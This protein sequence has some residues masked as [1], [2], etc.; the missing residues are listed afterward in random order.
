MCTD[1]SGIIDVYALSNQTLIDRLFYQTI[2]LVADMNFVRD[3]GV[4]GGSKGLYTA[5][6]LKK[7]VSENCDVFTAII[8]ETGIIYSEQQSGIRAPGDDIVGDHDIF[9]AVVQI[10]TAVV[11]IDVITGDKDILAAPDTDAVIPSVADNIV[12]DGGAFRIILHALRIENSL[13]LQ[14]DAVVTAFNTDAVPDDVV[15]IRPLSSADA[16]AGTSGTVVVPFPTAPVD[17]HGVNHHIVQHINTQGRSGG[18]QQPKIPEQRWP[19]LPRR[20]RLK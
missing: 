3:L 16:D 4:G 8:T 17:I 1:F 7:A 13:V 12:S 18:I 10:N 11:L 20:K 19:G 5:Y 15:L 9:C 6:V 14:E 2:C